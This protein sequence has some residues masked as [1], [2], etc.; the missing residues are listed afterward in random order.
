MFV[1]F[2]TAFRQHFFVFHTHTHTHARAT[3]VRGV[4]GVVYLSRCAFPERASP[5]F[6]PTPPPTAEIREMEE[7]AGLPRRGS[8]RK[9]HLAAALET[10][11]EAPSHTHT[12]THTHTQQQPV[13]KNG[14]CVGLWV[15][16]GRVL[17]VLGCLPAGSCERGLFLNGFIAESHYRVS[18]EKQMEQQLQSAPHAQRAFHSLARYSSLYRVYL[19]SF[20]IETLIYGRPK[21]RLAR[22]LVHNTSPARVVPRFT[23]LPSSLSS[24]TQFYRVRLCFCPGRSHNYWTRVRLDQLNS[25]DLLLPGFTGFYRVFSSLTQVSQFEALIEQDFDAFHQVL[26]SFTGFYWVLPSFTWS[27]SFF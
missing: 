4:H 1:V 7:A 12:H 25:I 8:E 23:R 20:V 3:P 19:P 26:P 5:P 14:F 22:L 27:K 9:R 15:G 6:T 17:L 21:S 16:G 13:S 2:S 11:N 24:F 10:K 18:A